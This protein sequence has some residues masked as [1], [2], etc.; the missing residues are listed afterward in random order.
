MIPQYQNYNLNLQN[1]Q[2]TCICAI[3]NDSIVQMGS[4]GNPPK[5]IGVTL[6]KYNELYELLKQYRD[7]LIELGV[8]EKEK[9]PEEVQKEN[10]D[11]LIEI[12]KRLDNLEKEKTNVRYQKDNTA[13]AELFPRQ[14]RKDK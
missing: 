8:I 10:Q 1:A 3:E 7:K 5:E 12:M 4:W 11:M 13:G 14:E 9:T 6:K 2:N